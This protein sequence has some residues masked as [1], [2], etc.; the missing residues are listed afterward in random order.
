MA[1]L[2]DEL[3]QEAIRKPIVS[4]LTLALTQRRT[5]RTV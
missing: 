3:Q 4:C 2:R 5:R 1:S